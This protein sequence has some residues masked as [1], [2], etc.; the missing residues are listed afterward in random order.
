M[1][2][3]VTVSF[4]SEGGAASLVSQKLIEMGF[5]S[6]IGSHDFMYDWKDKDVSPAEILNF[7]DRIQTKLK[8]QGIR[9]NVT[10]IR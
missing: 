3:Y 4:S 2:T 6:T 1:K 9:I 8:G 7:I 10:T 5:E